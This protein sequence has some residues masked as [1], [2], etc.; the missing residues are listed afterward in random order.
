ML[1]FSSVGIDAG[2][3]GTGGVGV[4][5]ADHETPGYCEESQ[6]SKLYSI[7]NIHIVR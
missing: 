6:Y 5:L 2:T 4:D 1:R 7:P 3:I